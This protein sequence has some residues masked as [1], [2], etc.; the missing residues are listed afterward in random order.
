[1]ISYLVLLPQSAPIVKFPNIVSNRSVCGCFLVKFNIPPSPRFVV[2][3]NLTH[4]FE[5]QQKFQVVAQFFFSSCGPIFS[6]FNHQVE[7]PVMPS[8]I[9]RRDHGGLQELISLPQGRV[10]AGTDLWTERKHMVELVVEAM[11]AI[12]F[13][14]KNIVWYIYIQKVYKCYTSNML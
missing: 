2:Y 11:I 6:P 8:G 4:N 1:M 14:R 9:Q 3:L 7:R 5:S 10:A 12:C 13:G